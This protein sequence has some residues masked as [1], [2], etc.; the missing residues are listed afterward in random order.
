VYAL[1]LLKRRRL[2]GDP[3]KSL[4][5][6]PAQQSDT[7]QKFRVA[8]RMLSRIVF[9]KDGIVI[10]ENGSTPRNLPGLGLP[11]HPEVVVVG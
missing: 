6:Q 1:E 5:I 8:F 11:A 10:N 3:L 9:Q 7:G 2:P 4:A